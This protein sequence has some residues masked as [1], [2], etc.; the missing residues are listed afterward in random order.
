LNDAQHF[1]ESMPVAKFLGLRFLER[2]ESQAVVALP[3]R[4]ELLQVAGVV[5][6]GI[7]ATLADTAAVYLL[8]GAGR[9]ERAM[10]SIEFKLNFLR[11]A[12]L[13][14]GE[15]LARAKL[16]KRG[17]TIA[18]ADVDVEQAGQLV[19]KGLFTYLFAES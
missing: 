11:P 15:L 3:L 6:G 19:A 2:N 18:L 8:L 7:L 9:P 12:L 5:H 10:T 17:R 16:V 1:V 4:A 14:Q 13:E